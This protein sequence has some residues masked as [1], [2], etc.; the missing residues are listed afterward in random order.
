MWTTTEANK[1]DSERDQRLASLLTAA[2]QGDQVAYENFLNET[3]VVLR[4]F[5]IKRMELD[6]VEDVIQETLLS[7][8][9]FL[10]TYL[11]GRPVGP[12]LYAICGHRMVDHY[13]QKR[14]IRRVEA[15]VDLDDLSVVR[16]GQTDRSLD[17]TALDA[18]KKLPSRQRRI[19]ELL[20]IQGLT[21]KEVSAETGMSESS[22]K[23]T[24]FRG[25]E[26]I[27]KLF[28]LKA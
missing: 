28:G 14:R 5:L 8:H 10:R 15:E 23:I 22:V 26:T 6:M 1:L 16:I 3:T 19:I 20:K 17:E 21:V 2:Q 13:R 4:R 9:R 12:W 25:Y 11:P 7:I 27:R 18:L 24:A